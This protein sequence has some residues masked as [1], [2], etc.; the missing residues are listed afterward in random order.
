[1]RTEQECDSR[2]RRIKKLKADFIKRYNLIYD[3]STYASELDKDYLNETLGE[4]R[5]EILGDD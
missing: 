3:G 2:N 1:M 5:K 4:I